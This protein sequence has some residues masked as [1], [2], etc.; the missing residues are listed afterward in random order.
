MSRRRSRGHLNKL[1]RELL[2]KDPEDRLGYSKDGT[3]VEDIKEHKFFKNHYNFDKI[4]K[5]KYESPYNPNINA[6]VIGKYK[7]AKGYQAGVTKNLETTNGDLGDTNLGN[8]YGQKIKK[9]FDKEEKK[10]K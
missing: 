9:R 1:I 10:Y 7:N 8:T 6:K 5:R 4:M 2:T 3:G